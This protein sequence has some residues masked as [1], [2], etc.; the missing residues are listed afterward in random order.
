M[1]EDHRLL[2]IAFIPRTT[3]RRWFCACGERGY[4]VK[5]DDDWEFKMEELWRQ[6]VLRKTGVRPRGRERRE[7]R[8]GPSLPDAG[9]G[10]FGPLPVGFVCEEGSRVYDAGTL[11][12]GTPCCSSCRRV[13]V[14]NDRDVWVHA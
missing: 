5:A 14:V 6:H 11:M 3:K 4:G 12:D 7:A 13:I 9:I 10:K 2:H 8:T 1:P